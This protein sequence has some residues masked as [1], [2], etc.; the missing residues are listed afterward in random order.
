MTL[1]PTRLASRPEAGVAALIVTL[2][3]DASHVDVLAA[4]R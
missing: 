1:E 4:V 3:R 2:Q